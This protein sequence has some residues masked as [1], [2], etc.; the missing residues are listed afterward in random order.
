MVDF[1]YLDVEPELLILLT[2][3]R[4]MGKVATTGIVLRAQIFSREQNL[5]LVPRIEGRLK[6]R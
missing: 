6:V 5:Y 2:L 4:W 1:G 3:A